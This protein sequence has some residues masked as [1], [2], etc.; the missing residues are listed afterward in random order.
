MGTIIEQEDSMAITHEAISGRSN[1]YNVDPRAII[2][3]NG[4][5]PRTDFSG[6]EELMASI[7]ENGVKL[8][9]S[10]KKNGEELLLIDGERR[11]RACLKLIAKGAE[12][13]SVP[14]LFTSNTI[15][16]TEALTLSLITNDGK[17]LDPTEE[18]DAFRRLKGWGLTVAE[19]AARIGKSTVHVYRRLILVDASP[20]LK[21]EI[22]AKNISLVE[23]EKIVKTSAGS[24]GKQSRKTRDASKSNRMSAKEIKALFESKVA[25]VYQNDYDKGYATALQN[26]MDKR[27]L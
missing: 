6:E 22:K 9:L 25:L 20:E 21:A 26:I 27:T 12:I 2:V 8:P 7:K 5:N 15:S 1:L 19:I 24:V 23:A 3:Q 10:L 16:D 13:K 4:W 17:R 11:L 14:C 18:A